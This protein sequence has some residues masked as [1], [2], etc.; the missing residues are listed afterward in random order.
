M[1]NKIEYE[2]LAEF[3]FA[4]AELRRDFPEFA[5][6]ID[7]CQFEVGRSRLG[8]CGH[9]G[10]DCSLSFEDFHALRNRLFRTTPGA[11]GNER[12]NRARLTGGK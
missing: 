11:W 7:K 9:G 10:C 5:R 3:G 6:E 8:T 1:K 4:V 2:R 12:E